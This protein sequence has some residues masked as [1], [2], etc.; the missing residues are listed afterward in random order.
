MEEVEEG[1]LEEEEPVDA[2]PFNPAQ[3]DDGKSTRG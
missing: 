1:Y 3:L 2:Y